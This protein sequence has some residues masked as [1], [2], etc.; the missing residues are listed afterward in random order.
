MEEE[1]YICIVGGGILKIAHYVLFISS[2]NKINEKMAKLDEI[3]LSCD[4]NR[5]IKCRMFPSN[6]PEKDMI[7]LKEKISKYIDGNVVKMVLNAL[8]ATIKE[9][10]GNKKMILW[11]NNE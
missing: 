6:N 11:K 8:S 5:V 10:T 4:N 1:K 2:K 3:Y 9:I 7:I